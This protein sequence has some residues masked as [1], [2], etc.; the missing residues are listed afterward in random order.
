MVRVEE[1][2]IGR[3]GGDG[4]VPGAWTRDGRGTRGLRGPRRFE[5][6][7]GGC[8]CSSSLFRSSCTPVYGEVLY[9]R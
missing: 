2:E 6:L 5:G 4:E 8:H 7:G 9:D 3:F 1:K